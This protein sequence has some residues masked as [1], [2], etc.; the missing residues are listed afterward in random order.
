MLKGCNN[1]DAEIFVVDNNSTDGSRDYL[2]PRFPM[3]KFIWNDNNSGFAK[4]NN[5]ALTEAEGEYILFLN[6]DT[7]V[8]EDC[9]EKCFKFFS[10]HVDAGAIGVHMIDGSGRFLKESKRAFPSPLTS[11]YKLA[12]LTKIFPRSKIFAKYYLGHLTEN[13]THEVD[14]LAG[15]FMMIPKKVIDITGGFDEIFFMY[16]EDVDLSYRIQE[17]INPETGAAYKNFYFPGISI[18]HF[19]GESTKRGE[20]NYVRVFYKA[21]SLFVK[22][23][24]S[25]GRASVFNFFIHV[26]IWIRAA[27]SALFV[28]LRNIRKMFMKKDSSKGMQTI[29][30]ANEKD[31]LSITTILQNGVT[32]EKILGRVSNSDRAADNALGTIGH[33]PELVKTQR[34]KEVIFCEEGLGFARII[35]MIQQLTP[36][37]LNM[38]HASGSS[39][40]IG[41]DSKY[42]RGEVISLIN[43]PHFS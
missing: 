33:L 40:I 9:F 37:I 41:S 6:P 25:G 1:I 23:H 18:I 11:F 35:S 22:K 12:G 29:I 4:A 13:E 19:K 15:A 20:L 32:G 26:G 28:L 24:Y 7:I 8:P 38:F 10:T 34:V 2:E 31:F 42:E 17:T 30:V 3:V 27:F 16:G 21:M 36:G 43:D 14:V 5:Q 39:S